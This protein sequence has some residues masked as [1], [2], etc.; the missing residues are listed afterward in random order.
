MSI[1]EK[2]QKKLEGGKFRL[3]NEKMYKNKELTEKEAQ[4]YHKYY[5]SQIKKWP[6]DPK[7][8]II[9]KIKENS[10]K[11]PK[12]ADLGCGSCEIANNFKNVDSYDKY[13]INDKVIQCELKNIASENEQYDI[14][15]CCLSLMMNNITL[16]LK[17]VNRILKTNGIYYLSEV[18]SRIKNM[19]AFIN[20]VEKFGFK[21]KKI[22]KSNPYFFILEL[23]K[24]NGIEKDAKMPNVQ[25]NQWKYKKR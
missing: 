24:Q 4:E 1:I 14:A 25:L 7:E 18:T 19:K 6:S 13:P 5:L 17:E 11:D 9:T 20:N 3:L 8:L 21:L 10:K 2:L 16:V 22:D 23:E 15:V 12:I